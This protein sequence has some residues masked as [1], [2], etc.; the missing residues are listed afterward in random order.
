MTYFQTFLLLSNN[1]SAANTVA[2]K[3]TKKTFTY[4]MKTLFL[5]NIKPSVKIQL[6]IRNI[7]EPVCNILNERILFKLPFTQAIVVKRKVICHNFKTSL[8]KFL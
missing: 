7:V 8:L 5:F 6:S 1:A 3:K 4:R 2:C